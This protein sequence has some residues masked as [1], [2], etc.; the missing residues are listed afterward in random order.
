MHDIWSLVKKH[1]VL[2]PNVVLKNEQLAL[3]GEKCYDRLSG[4]LRLVFDDSLEKR[5]GTGTRRG[6]VGDMPWAL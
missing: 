2:L 5:K 1:N 4:I 3:F 6:C